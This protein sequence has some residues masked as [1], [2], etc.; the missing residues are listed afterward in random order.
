MLLG[1]A[2]VGNGDA[3]AEV[4]RADAKLGR[5]SDELTSSVKTQVNNFLYQK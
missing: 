5:V 2:R 3:A 4:W 1:N